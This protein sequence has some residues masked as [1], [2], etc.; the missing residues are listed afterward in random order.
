M[1]LRE[2][3]QVKNIYIDNIKPEDTP[4][5]IE[6]KRSIFGGIAN[7]LEYEGEQWEEIRVRKIKDPQYKYELINGRRG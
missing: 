2:K 6:L 4:F 5:E 3:Y 7:D 1:R